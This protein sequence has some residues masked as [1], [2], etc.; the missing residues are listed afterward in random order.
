MEGGAA[1]SAPSPSSLVPSGRP[2][3]RTP[4][5]PSPSRPRKARRLTELGNKILSDFLKFWF[6][7]LLRSDPRVNGGPSGGGVYPWW[8]SEINKIHGNCN[9][10][11]T[12]N[13]WLVPKHCLCLEDH[14]SL[15]KRLWCYWTSP[16]GHGA[17]AL[18]WIFRTHR[19]KSAWNSI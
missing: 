3:P 18:R 19:Q 14:L 11:H 1:M 15:E 5:L 10:S 7:K 9:V 16:A 2:C 8:E 12:G 6:H 13:C 4:R 17:E